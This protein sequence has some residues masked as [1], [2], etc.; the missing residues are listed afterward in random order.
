MPD[1]ASGATALEGRYRLDELI[2]R[3]GMA[4]V[5]RAHDLR[6]DRDVAVKTLREVEHGPRFEVEVRTLAALDHPN[7]VRLLDAGEHDGRPFLVMELL[8]GASVLELLAGGPVPPDRVREI[9]G[10]AA[11][12]L[13]DIH[14]RGIVH[15]D[16]KPS[17]LMFDEHGTLRIA[18]FGIVHLADGASL[19]GTHQTIGTM[20]YLAPEQLRGR[21]ITPVADVYSLGLVLLECLTGT[22]AFTGPPA[23]AAAARL[24]HDADV[25]RSLPAPWPELLLAMT[26]RDP[27]ARPTARDVRDRLLATAEHRVVPVVPV[28]AVTPASATVVMPTAIVDEAAATMPNA[29]VARTRRRTRSLARTLLV[30]GGFALALAVGFGIWQGI[31]DDPPVTPAVSPSTTV[32]PATTTAPVVTT[33][34][35]PPPP[36]TTSAPVA[37]D[38]EDDDAGDGGAVD[39]RGPGPGGGKGKD[40]GPG[41]GPGKGGGAEDGDD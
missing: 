10:E 22:R 26:A 20:A 4:D 7:L 35:P 33:A 21:D 29:E 5:H 19:T 36:P 39:R 25:P 16:V 14:D 34:P 31:A 11:A 3:G 27:A 9:G 38:D 28:A 12:G 2:G 13:A 24:H 40:K 30:L 37:V 18:D 1:L 6:L 32:A 23:E 8:G 17:N 41:G 15:R